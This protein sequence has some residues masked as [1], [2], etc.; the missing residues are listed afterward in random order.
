MLIGAV[1]EARM[2]NLSF[3]K[4]REGNCTTRLSKV[5]E[6]AAVP[7]GNRRLNKQRKSVFFL[8]VCVFVFLRKRHLLSSSLFSEANFIASRHAW[9]QRP[10]STVKQYIGQQLALAAGI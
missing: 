1:G 2:S 5:G 7:M 9:E 8:C 6:H 10:I 4:W 3:W